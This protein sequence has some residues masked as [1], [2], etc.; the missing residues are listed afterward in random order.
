V[1]DATGDLWSAQWAGRAVLRFGRDGAPKGRISVPAVNVTTLCFGGPKLDEMRI[2][3]ATDG[4][5]P[6]DLEA[7]PLTGSLFS[8][9]PGEVGQPEPLFRI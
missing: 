6:D 5:A 4:V 3:S 9:E 1:V 8:A 7:L 2:I